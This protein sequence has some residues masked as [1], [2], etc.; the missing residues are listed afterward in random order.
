MTEERINQKLKIF[1]EEMIRLQSS[2]LVPG[3]QKTALDLHNAM[4]AR[5]FFDS[6]EEEIAS[7]QSAEQ[8]TEM[9]NTNV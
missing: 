3:Q 5:G 7:L 6:R 1:E 9:D 4:K 8:C 2:W